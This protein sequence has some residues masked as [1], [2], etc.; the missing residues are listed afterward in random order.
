[1]PFWSLI[2]S[3]EMNKDDVMKIQS[4]LANIE[5][6]EDGKRLMGKLGVKGFVP[7]NQQDYVDLLNWLEKT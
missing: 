1:M 2:A 6:T 4:A 7:G 5:N 3:S